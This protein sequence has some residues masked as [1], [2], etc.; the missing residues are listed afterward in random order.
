LIV[1]YVLNAAVGVSAGVE[2]VT[3]AFPGLYGARVW[4]CLAAL[5]LITGANFWGVAESARIFIIPTVLFI[6]A[7][8]VVIITGLVRTHPAVAPAHRLPSVTETVGTLLI[9][10]AF[11]SG[12]SALTGVEAIANAVPEFR[13][14][15]ERRAQHTEMWL[16]IILGTMLLGLAAVIRKFDVTPDGN[17]TVLAELTKIGVGGGALFYIIQIITLILLVLAANTSFG[18]LPV[19]ASIVAQDNFLP[20]FFHL[21]AERQVH[22]YGVGVL[23]VFAAILLIVSRGDTQALIPL[24]AIGVFVGFTLAQAGMVRHWHAEHKPGWMRRAAI[25]GSARYSRSPPSSS[26]WWPSSPRVPG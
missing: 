13:K 9:L 25:N 4:L 16:G 8:A 12:C 10:K 18:G 23:A 6:V 7:I 17:V 26:S 5:A 21:K 19:L 1:D 22:R 14:P 15:R 2:A 11:A 20:H 24:F 3:S